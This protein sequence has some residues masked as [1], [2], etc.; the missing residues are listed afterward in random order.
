MGQLQWGKVVVAGGTGLVGR[1]LV[2]ALVEGGTQVT[3]LTRHPGGARL[4]PGAVASAWED[5]DGAVAGADAV[6]NLAGEG[7]ADRRWS[8]A[9]KALLRLS[10]TET[11]SRLVTAIIQSDPRPKVLVNASAVGFYGSQDGRPLD[12]GAPA[13]RGFLADLCRAW[14]READR[15]ADVGVRLVKL[16][17]GVVLAREGGAL[18]KMALPVKLFQGAALGSGQQGLS[19]IHLEDLVR[20]T[21]VAAGDEAYRGPVNATAPWPVS[22]DTFTRLLGKALRRPVL[23]IPGFLTAAALRVLVGE[24]ADDMLLS[25]NFAYPRKAQQLGF[26]FRFPTAEAALADLIPGAPATLTAGPRTFR[27]RQDPP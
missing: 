27:S 16:R 7:I 17:L 1:A 21:L 4:T 11:T 5:V 19:W 15:V 12:E 6:F 20:L 10:R 23:P 24:M 9:R 2:Q 3:V 8:P 25:G 26:A 13:G 18:P 22:N 14:E